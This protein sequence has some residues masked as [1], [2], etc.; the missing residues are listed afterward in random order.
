MAKAAIIT[1]GNRGIGRA[2]ALELAERGFD[3][4]ITYRNHRDEATRTVADIELLGQA[5]YAEPLDFIT[6]TRGPEAIDALA[7]KL[8]GLDVLVNNAGINWRG[9][10]LDLSLDDLLT[11]TNVNLFGPVLCARAAAHRMLVDGTRGRIVNVTSVLGRAPL[12]GALA[13]CATNAAMDAATEV[14]ALE[15]AQQGI[16]VNAVAVGHTATAMN[17]FA[18][19]VD[20]LTVERPA[21]PMG[22]PADPR[23]I[24]K[25]IAFLCEADSSYITGSNLLVDGGL[26][27]V[28]GPTLLAAA[29]ADPGGANSR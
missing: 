1:G 25:A 6:P 28:Q 11:V 12:G 3:I 10:F 23:E 8:G 9:S 5:A 22:R 15:L 21:I 19:D 2:S 24:A 17:G 7:A 13:Y 20:V 27:L 26:L 18:K 4:G 14:M 29:T 16:A